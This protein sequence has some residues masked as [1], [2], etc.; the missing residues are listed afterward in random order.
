[1]SLEGQTLGKYR[2]LDPLGRGGMARV[3]R[4]YH[5]HLDRYVAIKVLRADL[6]ED[7]AFLARFQR[8]ARAVAALRHPNIVQ[9]HDCD[10]QDDVYY[11]VMELLEGDTLKAR[12][13][14]YRAHN[15]QMPLGE[16][17]RVLLDVL[18]GLSYAHSEGMIHRDIKPANI[19]LTKRGQAVITDF[20]I[21]QIIGS[22]RYTVSGA[23]MGT[24]NYM[25]PEQG[26]EGKCDARC[27]IYS[28][29]IVLYEMLTDRVP[30]DADT[31]L[32][33]LMKHLNDPL[34]LPRTLVPTIPEPLER[35]V[36]KSLSKAPKDRY[37]T[38]DEMA[39]ALHA[40][41]AE[42]GIELPERISLPRSFTTPEAPSESVAVLSGT[43]RDGIADARFAAD[44]TDTSLK[45]R[46]AAERAAG[47]ATERATRSPGP[48][49]RQGASPRVAQA[50]GAAAASVLGAVGAVIALVGGGVSRLAPG[51]DRFLTAKTPGRA[52]R[53]VLS[54]IGIVAGYNLLAVW[55]GGLTGWW[56]LY[57]I[58]WPLEL[59]VVSVALAVLM[60]ALSSIWLAI[61]A[62]IIL[63]NGILFS[64]CQVT[65]NWRHWAFLWPLELMLVGGTVWLTIWLAKRGRASQRIARPMG[66]ALGIVGLVWGTII[67]AVTMVS[68]LFRWVGG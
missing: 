33:I 8:E 41:A 24:L 49:K 16:M 12:L 34:P 11:M 50:S 48:A 54:A 1:M 26:L 63:G 68:G 66:C 46:L 51:L 21:A 37:A 28:L 43:A 32:A 5:P 35:V 27:D 38:A 67:V 39:Q 65:G 4:A 15:E 17:V 22:T 10:L 59:I 13:N 25:A 19:L 23:L 61:P 2:V 31:P 56:G 9:V 57:E 36:L 3:Y 47:G 7:S 40:A 60:Y 6:V 52:V 45:Q 58:G 30:F 62:S 64:Y 14:D 29:G 53:V 42:A 55:V 20:G 18:E 44:E